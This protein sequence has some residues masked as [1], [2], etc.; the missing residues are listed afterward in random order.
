MNQ[1]R[2]GGHME[3]ID[4]SPEM[5]TLVGVG[6]LGEHRWPSDPVAFEL[7]FGTAG[8][9]AQF[10][11]HENPTPCLLDR[12]DAAV[13]LILIVDRKACDRLL[14]ANLGL[15]DGSAYFLPCEQRAIALAIRDCTMPEAAAT[16]YRLAKSIELLCEILGAHREDRLSNADGPAS[17]SQLDLQRI[18]A[19]RQLI[20]EQWTEKLTL[21]QIARHCGLNRS[22]LSRGFRELYHCTV[23]EALAE[24]R[25]GEASRQLIAT[26]LPVSLIGY[27]SGYLNNASFSRAFGRS[28]GVSPSDFR[29][30]AVAA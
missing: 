15:G 13:R 2:C 1:F 14:G 30:C 23:S 27:R 17:L 7:D 18:A 6:A 25:L 12:P 20:D 19:A 24:R 29:A 4:V 5:L 16:P 3:A 21:L 9:A 26:D 28:F 22:K 8:S 10:S 11:F